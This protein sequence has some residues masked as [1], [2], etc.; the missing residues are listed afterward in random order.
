MY[1]ES[2]FKCSKHPSRLL[3]NPFGTGATQHSRRSG[4]ASEQPAGWSKRPS[5]AAAASDLPA[6]EAAFSLRSH[7]GEGG[8][9]KAWEAKGVLCSVRRASE[10]PENKAGGPFDG[11]YPE[12]GRRAQG[13]LFQHP[14]RDFLTRGVSVIGKV[15]IGEF[16]WMGTEKNHKPGRS[17]KNP[18]VPDFR[19]FPGTKP[20]GGITSQWNVTGPPST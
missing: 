6:R 16:L 9:A 4:T 18:Q 15:K 12:Q 19:I 8:S 11:V 1:G 20:S 17:V 7:F 2:A 10:R 3:K 5:G 13:M 14:A